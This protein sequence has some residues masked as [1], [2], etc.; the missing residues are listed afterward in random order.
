V[1]AEPSTAVAPTATAPIDTES[2]DTRFTVMIEQRGITMKSGPG[3]I[4]AAHAVCKMFSE[5]DTPDSIA[6]QV[7]RQNPGL[8]PQL[9]EVFV[10]I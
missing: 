2:Q 6:P 10:V 3:S 5:G 9:A 7:V 4:K 8:T 1:T